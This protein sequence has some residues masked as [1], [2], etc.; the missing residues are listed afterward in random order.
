MRGWFIPKCS[1]GW[2][3][4]HLRCGQF[5]TRRSL[6]FGFLSLFRP[7]FMRMQVV[8]K[9]QTWSQMSK[10]FNKRFKRKASTTPK[11]ASNLSLTRKGCTMNGVGA[12]SFQRLLSGCFSIDT[13]FFWKFWN[14]FYF[15]RPLLVIGQLVIS[16]WLIVIGQIKTPQYNWPVTNW[17]ITIYRV[18]IPLTRKSLS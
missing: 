18:I 1:D 9:A 3:F 4:F 2:W 13:V 12:R 11:L 14:K 5:R 8:E 17:P 6:R 16:Y 10:I 15:C 7:K